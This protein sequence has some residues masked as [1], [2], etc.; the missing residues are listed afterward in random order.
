MKKAE[1]RETLKVKWLKGK[2]YSLII[3]ISSDIMASFI[4]KSNA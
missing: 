2:Q 1:S 3:I 4:Y